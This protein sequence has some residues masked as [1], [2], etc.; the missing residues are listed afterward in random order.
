MTVEFSCKRLSRAL[1]LSP[2]F[3]GHR[4]SWVQETVSTNDD[5]KQSWSLPEITP[6]I[7]IAGYQTAGRGQSGRSWHAAPGQ[8]LLFSFSLTEIQS[9][10]P[11]SMIAGLALYNAI[12]S[13]TKNEKAGLWL[14]W[15]NDVWL[16][17]GKLAGVLCE[18]C[19]ISSRQNWVVGVGINLVPLQN[20]EFTAA[21]LSEISEGLDPEEVLCEFFSSFAGLLLESADSLVESWSKAASVFWQTRFSFSCGAS[22]EF[23]GLPLAIEADGSLL[24]DS[25]DK[26][27][28]RLVSATLKPLF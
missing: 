19:S 21:S 10:F 26:K 5:L 24:V 22:R 18:G 25:G 8:S 17:R 13:L 15:P 3:S 7:R 9:S 28:C 2:V 4:I 14:K 23:C 12:R 20:T 27:S 6:Q 16:N 1:A 11:L